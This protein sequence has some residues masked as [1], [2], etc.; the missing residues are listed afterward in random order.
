[1]SHEFTFEQIQKCKKV[2]DEHKKRDD[3]DSEAKTYCFRY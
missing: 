2:F 1:M 3:N